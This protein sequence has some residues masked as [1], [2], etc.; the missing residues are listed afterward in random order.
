[1]T[2]P[3]LTN[4][5][6]LLRPTTT[7]EPRRSRN[8]GEVPLWA[9]NHPPGWLNRRRPNRRKLPL[10]FKLVMLIKKVTSQ[11]YLCISLIC[12]CTS[13]KCLR[14][15]SMEFSF[16]FSCAMRTCI[17]CRLLKVFSIV[18][19]VWQKFRAVWASMS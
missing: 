9:T 15:L 4:W 6:K 14:L 11:I 16:W 8:T 12:S 3:L 5:S 7:K 18:D 2:V 17:F 13:G 1:M 19:S 10:R